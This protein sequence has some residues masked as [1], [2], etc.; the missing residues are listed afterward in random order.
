MQYDKIK[1]SNQR[2]VHAFKTGM[3]KMKKRNFISRFGA[4]IAAVSM[5]TASFAG[6]TVNAQTAETVPAAE[7]T[8]I[9]AASTLQGIISAAVT[10]SMTN[11]EKAEAVTK[12]VADNY[13]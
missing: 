12:Y 13:S 9:N 4:V 3:G 7:V 11:A 1:I 5:F 6:T 8:Q 2:G 10:S